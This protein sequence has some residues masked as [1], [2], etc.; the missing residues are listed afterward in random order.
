MLIW[1]DPSV[2]TGDFAT[3]HE[4]CAGIEAIFGAVYRG[5]HY[6]LGER[7]TLIALA[8]KQDLSSTTRT[9]IN[10]VVQRLPTLGCIKEMVV[11]RL[12]VTNRQ[13]AR[14]RRVDSNRWEVPLKHIAMWGVK[15]TALIAENLDDARAFEHAAKQYIAF[16]RMSG[17]V[18]LERFSGGGSTTH[19]CF[20]N[21][22]K[23]EKRW[24][25]CITDSDRF[26]P[27]DDMNTTANHCKDVASCDSVAS[28]VDFGAREIENIVPIRFLEEA[29]PPTRQWICEHHLNRFYRVRPDAHHFCDI[30]KG[31]TLKEV[32]SF[33]QGTPKR[34]FWDSVISDLRRSSAFSSDCIDAS[35]CKEQNIG[36]CQCHVTQG[37][38]EGILRSVVDM[39]D[40]RGAHE[41]ERHVRHDQSRD[42]WMDIGRVVFEWACAP[43]KTRL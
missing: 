14:L 9:L 32:F 3:D 23:S 2:L 11:T 36:P 22:V 7:E 28:H 6:A 26:C 29:I 15:K 35:G 40:R 4:T 27:A 37:F 19:R 16:A 33:P 17:D 25:L 21:L 43:H 24:C 34:L 8:G 42:I 5:E 31:M 13:D 18:A 20:D 30:K 41:S 10:T 39:L 38:G 12:I 1:L